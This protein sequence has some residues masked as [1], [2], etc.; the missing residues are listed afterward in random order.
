M[1]E[2]LTQFDEAAMEMPFPRT[3]RGQIYNTGQSGRGMLNDPPRTS[4][5]RI[6]AHGPQL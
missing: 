3:L 2:A 5:T 4:A 1:L 6:H